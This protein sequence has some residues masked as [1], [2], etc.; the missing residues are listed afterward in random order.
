MKQQKQPPEVFCKNIYSQKFRKIYRKHLYQSLFFNKVASLRPAILLKKRLWHRCFPVNF[1][2]F[3]ITPFSQNT[4]R[5]LLLKQ[6]QWQISAGK[7]WLQL[8]VSK[9]LVNYFWRYFFKGKK[10]KFALFTVHV[11]HAKSVKWSNYC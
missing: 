5:R 7:T 4:S 8:S 3:L 2:K 6:T 9:C 11:Q 10:G 1:A